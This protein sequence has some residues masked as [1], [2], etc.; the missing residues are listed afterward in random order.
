MVTHVMGRHS[1]AFAAQSFFAAVLFRQ[2]STNEKKLPPRFLVITFEW[3]PFAK[4]RKQLFSDDVS[5]M[6]D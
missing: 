6:T 5:P 2:V 4:L 1:V 3:Q